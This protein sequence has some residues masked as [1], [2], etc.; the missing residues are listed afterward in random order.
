MYTLGQ[1]HMTLTFEN[2][3]NAVIYLT[4]ESGKI[5][6]RGKIDT[7]IGIEHPGIILGNDGWGNQRIVHHHYKHI[8]P[9]VDFRHVYAD[10]EVIYDDLR[11]VKY[12]RREIVARAL[13]LWQ[14]RVTYNLFLSNCQ[15]FVNVATR[16]ER[17]SESL[18]EIATGVAVG[19]GVAALLG[20]LLDNEDLV[21]VG[22][23]VGGAGLA[24][25]VINRI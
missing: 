1:N 16:N 14:N 3:E 4:P 18:D 20:W 11:P 22:L 10:G 15:T 17:Q 25:K 2:G 13:E 21:K 7:L 5:V 23:T 12:S 6:S 19:G 24:G 8:I 9:V